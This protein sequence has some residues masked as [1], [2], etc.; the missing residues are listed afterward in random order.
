MKE[1]R[2]MLSIE[3]VLQIVPVSPV[4]SS[5]WNAPANFRLVATSATTDV[6]GTRTN[7]SRGKTHCRRIVGSRRGNPKSGEA[8][9]PSP[10]GGKTPSTRGGILRND[11]IAVVLWCCAGAST[12]VAFSLG[13][14]GS[15]TVA[16]FV[17]GSS[18]FDLNQP[19]DAAAPQ[20]ASAADINIGLHPN[21]RIS[22]LYK[23]GDT[24]DNFLRLVRPTG[25]C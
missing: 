13:A 15:V 17:T 8:F 6:F 3:Q 12:R 24:Y 20:C 14:T 16:G 5:A 4:R 25:P 19:Q 2:R 7:W 11:C 21:H 1:P 9:A 10:A 18:G 23:F 22:A